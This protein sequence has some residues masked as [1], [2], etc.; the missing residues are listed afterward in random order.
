MV[1]HPTFH[2]GRLLLTISLIIIIK[3]LSRFKQ[4]I[5]VFNYF[6]WGEGGKGVW[7]F[8]KLFLNFRK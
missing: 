2:I 4:R 6:W 3:S 7:V 1:L 8:E 5:F